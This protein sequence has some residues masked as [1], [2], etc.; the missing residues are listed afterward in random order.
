[1]VEQQN[2]M[3]YG[4]PRLLQRNTALTRPLNVVFL[5][6]VR[7]TGTCDRNGTWVITEDGLEQ[8]MEGIIERTI[9]E[10]RPNGMLA[11][12][13][14]VVGVIYDDTE[15]DMRRID[16][17]P[18]L[19]NLE[20]WIY[21]Y[22][23]AT[24]DGLLVRDMTYNISS[25]FRQCRLEAKG[26]RRQAKFEFETEVLKKIKE[27]EGDI[28]VSDHYMARLDYLYRE[29][30]L[31]GCV[32]NIH[33]AVT[34]EK[35]PFCFRGKTPTADAIAR[36][37]SGV[38]TRTGAT[39]HFINERIDEGPPIAY[40]AETQVF[41]TDEPQWLRYRNYATCKLPLF[42][43]GLAYYVRS[44]YPYLDELDDDHLAKMQP[45]L[46]KDAIDN[47]ERA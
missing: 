16:S 13:V 10:T 46:I 43:Q 32:L 30:N 3:C 24:P 19:P 7:D 17:Y 12:L 23:L 31:Y 44:I 25:S 37:R 36:A 2:I 20:Q 4:D 34:V 21:P 38:P 1:M 27:L 40:V 42:V 9:K 18:L 5:T 47:N 11:N 28:L 45:F 26:E 33:P 22:D 15:R 14:R 29:P 35:H 6:S 39:L 41:A 8:Y